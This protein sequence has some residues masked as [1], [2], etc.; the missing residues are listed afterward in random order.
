MDLD[1]DRASNRAFQ[2]CIRDSEGEVGL[3]EFH[4]VQTVDRT[5]AVDAAGAV[6]VEGD[7]AA[8]AAVGRKQGYWYHDRVGTSP[9]GH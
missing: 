4:T 2:D 1:G 3:V 5:G 8:D 6:D 9:Q 7:A